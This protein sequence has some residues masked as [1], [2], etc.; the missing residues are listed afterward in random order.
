MI[1]MDATHNPRVDYRIYQKPRVSLILIRTNVQPDAPFHALWRDSAGQASWRPVETSDPVPFADSRTLL[2]CFSPVPPG[3]DNKSN[4][5]DDAVVS[6]EQ[7][8]EH[9]LITAGICQ[10]Q[11]E[12]AQAEIVVSSQSA[13]RI[14]AI[15]DATLS[16]RSFSLFFA[17]F[18]I[19]GSIL[20]RLV[21]LRSTWIS[22]DVTATL[23]VGIVSFVTPLWIV[24]WVLKA[25][26]GTILGVS[27]LLQLIYRSPHR[28]RI[29]IFLFLVAAP[30]SF[31]ASP[32]AMIERYTNLNAD[33][34]IAAMGS[35][36]DRQA[37]TYADTNT[38]FVIGYSTVNA[39][40]AGR[41]AYG[42][43]AVDQVL[44]QNC[45]TNEQWGRHA[46]D[47]GNICLLTPEW[48]RI[49]STMP[50]LQ[51]RLFMGGFNDDMTPSLRSLKSV[52]PSLIALVPSGEPFPD[53]VNMWGRAAT[54]NVQ[55]QETNQHAKECLTDLTATHSHAP[56][57]FVYDLGVF[58]LGGERLFERD[59]W[60]RTRKQVVE[61]SGGRFIDMRALLP[62]ESLMYF[63]D[64]VHP[65]EVG[66]R[67][68]ATHLCPLLR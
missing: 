39:A 10:W 6:F 64:F 65:S 12:G 42:S 35:K 32:L 55:S 66:Y 3:T 17:L 23:F 47:G 40:A 7:T 13:T 36:D 63:N 24:L 37:T 11:R 53:M 60:E 27:I 15:G 44:Q 68:L 62:G 38:Q 22:A 51:K 16:Q 28:V 20:S 43:A 61:S 45:L 18:I 41:G 21:F 4:E 49:A 19:L 25:S 33:K 1:H 9:L 2:D 56:L 46:V 50:Q 59:H 54:E 30:L 29:V 52:L 5:R 8:K 67:T 31:V 48:N 57:T 58:D 14:E 26:L 34:L